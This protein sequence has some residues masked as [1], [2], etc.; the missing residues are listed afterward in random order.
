MLIITGYLEY[1][2]GEL[3]YATVRR[4]VGP[5]VAARHNPAR[6][7]RAASRSDAD[8]FREL[9]IQADRVPAAPWRRL[10]NES[11]NKHER[12]GD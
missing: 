5:A 9:P 2:S 8:T 10:L 6:P 3:Y 4:S 12:Y 1:K 11:T 7:G